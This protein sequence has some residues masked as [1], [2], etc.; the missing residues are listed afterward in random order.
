MSRPCS[1]IK[2]N[3]LS[4]IKILW[5]RKL[6]AFYFDF[7]Y[8]NLMWCNLIRRKIRLNWSDQEIKENQIKL[9][10]T[11]QNLTK[12]SR[13]ILLFIPMV[14]DIIS[15]SFFTFLFISFYF[16]QFLFISFY[17]FLFHFISFYF[18]LFVTSIFHCFLSPSHSSSFFSFP[19][20][21]LFTTLSSHFSS[22]LRLSFS[23]HISKF[24]NR[25][26][27]CNISWV[28]FF[29]YIRKFSTSF[30][31]FIQKLSVI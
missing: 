6:P 14:H 3:V 31:Y 5:V 4:N 7:Y 18:V 22:G 1:K 2:V 26:Q 25:F 10:R 29:F 30:H 27:N 15:C 17:F 24:M 9:T 23:T 21:L 28:N 12:Q 16:L 11:K 20:H 8:F 19:F 13:I